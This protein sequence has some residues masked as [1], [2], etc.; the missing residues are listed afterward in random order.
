M[1]KI[2][3]AG[4]LFSSGD[5][6]WSREIKRAILERFPQLEVVWPYEISGE[7]IFSTNLKALDKCTYIVAI[8]DGAQVDDG[9]AW[10]VGYHYARRGRD[11]VLGIRTDFR[12][13]G[14][15]DGSQVNAM[16]ES[17]CRFISK[18]LEELLSEI[19]TILSQAEK[20]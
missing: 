1:I 12:R 17:S 19:E 9:T 7:D 10:E 4:P 11:F 18:S 5:I 8:L 15:R 14:E 3:L 6:S 16:I 13:A 20:P 2:Y